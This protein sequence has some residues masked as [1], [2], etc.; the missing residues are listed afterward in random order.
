MRDV[1]EAVVKRRVS[2]SV[3][4]TLA[5]AAFVADAPGLLSTS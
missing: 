1:Q 2:T 5:M 4:N 3:A